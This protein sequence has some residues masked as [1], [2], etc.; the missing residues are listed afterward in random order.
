MEPGVVLLHH[1]CRW[2]ML[3][4][5]GPRC[6][7]KGRGA[8]RRGAAPGGWKPPCR[9]NS[10]GW[11]ACDVHAVCTA[12]HLLEDGRLLLVKETGDC[13]GC[14]EG[15]VGVSVGTSGGAQVLQFLERK[16]N[17]L[18]APVRCSCVRECR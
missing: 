14:H 8:G 18:F 16:W 1:T 15:S 2:G 17:A 7:C 5:A 3:P 11:R 9:S 10:G 4:P 13:G 12:E 6:A